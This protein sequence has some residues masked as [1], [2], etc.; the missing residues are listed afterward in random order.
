MRPDFFVPEQSNDGFILSVVPGHK[1]LGVQV[2]D[3]QRIEHNLAAALSKQPARRLME[4]VMPYEPKIKNAATRM[5]RHPAR[6]A[7]DPATDL[8]LVIPSGLKSIRP[9]ADL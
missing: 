6:A 3:L 9:V 8:R 5:Q 4:L 2:L 1:A 7:Q